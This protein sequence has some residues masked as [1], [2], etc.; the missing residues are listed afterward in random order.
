M[1]LPSECR[2][3]DELRAQI[4]RLDQELVGLLVARTGYID[5][6]IDLKTSAQLPARIEARVDEVLENVRRLAA[7]QGLDPELAAALWERIIEWSI[8]REERVLG[9]TQERP[10]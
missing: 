10:E 2:N 5:R 1:R 9:K 3:M 7:Q 8:A 6:A 4:D